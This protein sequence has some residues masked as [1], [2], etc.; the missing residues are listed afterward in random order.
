M[1]GDKR[2]G[3]GGMYESP[4]IRI[5][6]P[7]KL[8]INKEKVSIHSNDQLMQWPRQYDKLSLVAKTN[9]NKHEMVRSCANLDVGW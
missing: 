3:N 1:F 4:S 5:G 2:E 8:T 6:F 7:C 9:V